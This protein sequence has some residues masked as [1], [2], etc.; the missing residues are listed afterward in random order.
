MTGHHVQSQDNT[1]LSKEQA[2]PSLGVL[3]GAGKV[4]ASGAINF[5]MVAELGGGTGEQRSG[6]REG[7]SREGIPFMIEGTTADP[8]F[9][10]DGERYGSG[11]AQ[12]AISDKISPQGESSKKGSAGRSRKDSRSLELSKRRKQCSTR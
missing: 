12:Q 11:A 9:V 3:T 5:K 8:K 4:N 2:V 7:R 10:P 6:R 1:E